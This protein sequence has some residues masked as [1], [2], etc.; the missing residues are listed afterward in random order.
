MTLIMCCALQRALNDFFLF[1][2]NLFHSNRMT[3][4]LNV[5]LELSTNNPLKDALKLSSHYLDEIQ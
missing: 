1:Y 2:R 4:V 3:I 5:T